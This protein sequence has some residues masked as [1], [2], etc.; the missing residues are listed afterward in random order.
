MGQDG[1]KDWAAEAGVRQDGGCFI[2]WRLSG[3][4]LV[5][6]SFLYLFLL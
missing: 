4:Q 5:P 6:V 2:F 3:M 1:K